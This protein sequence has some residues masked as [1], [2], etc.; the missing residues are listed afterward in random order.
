MPLTSEEGDVLG[1]AG[2]LGSEGGDVQGHPGPPA[3]GSGVTAGHGSSMMS[4]EMAA[5]P[6]IDSAPYL[7][8]P[9]LTVRSGLSL[10]KMLLM[11]IPGKPGPGVL[12][13]ANA[14]RASVTDLDGRWKASQKTRRVKDMRP[15]DV[16]L[17]RAWAVVESSLDRYTLLRPSNANRKRAAQLHEP[18]FS[19]GLAFLKLRYIEQHAES[20]RRIDLIKEEGL[21]ED[22][23]R[24]VGKEFIDELHAAHKAY[25]DA[26]GITKA[27]EASVDAES[28]LEPL[29]GVGRAISAYALQVLAFAGLDPANVPAARRAL[30]PIDKFRAAAAKRNAAGGATAEGAEGG[31][32]EDDVALPEDAPD[33]EAE[34]P[35]VPAG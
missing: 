4:G 31:E 23:D 12:G 17:D 6:M 2:P 9:R 3:V 11:V 21:R 18:L 32:A 1:P 26:L 7:Q 24:L 30:E 33:P 13:A 34:V 29:R 35:E 10:S 22:L 19:E 15:L 16:Q 5:P 8:A 20:A 27:G 14:L 28:L 25:G